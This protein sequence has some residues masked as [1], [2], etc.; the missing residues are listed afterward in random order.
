VKPFFA[1]I[2]SVLLSVTPAVFATNTINP[3]EASQ[4]AGMNKKAAQK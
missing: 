3:A 2:L 4:H 1:L